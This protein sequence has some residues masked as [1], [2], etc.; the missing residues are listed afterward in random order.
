MSFIS[1]LIINVSAFRIKIGEKLITLSN[2]IGNLP[3]LNTNN[4]TNLVA[5][6]N[7]V[8]ANSIQTLSTG[9]DTQPGRVEISN[10]NAIQLRDLSTGTKMDGNSRLLTSAFKP[11]VTNAGMTN[12]PSTTVGAG[13]RIERL[14]TSIAQSGFDI[15]KVANQDYLWYKTFDGLDTE[16]NWKILA[17]RD[18]IT[19]QLG[20]FLPLTGGLMNLDASIGLRNTGQIDKHIPSTTGGWARN[21]IRLVNTSG[22]NVLDVGMGYYG[23]GETIY[24][25]YMG[26][27]AYNNGN[28]IRWTPDSKVGINMSA[29][30]VPSANLDVNG[31][32]RFRNLQNGLLRT[33]GSGNISID[34]NSYALLSQVYT[35]AQA[36]GLFVG[37]NGVETINDTKTFSSSPVVPNGTLLGHTVNLGQ[38]NS[39]IE[40]IELTPGPAGTNGTNGKTWYSSTA[41]PANTLGVVGDF[42]L[43]TTTWDV[44]EKT[45]TSVWTLRGNIK[46]ETGAQG[47]AGTNGANGTSATI[48]SAS[49]TVNANVGTPAVSVTLG[50]T[51]SARTFAFAFS[52]LK[53]ATGNTGA[54]G[55]TGS[56][57]TNGIDG[58]T[59]LSGTTNPA[60]SLGTIGDWYLNRTTWIMFEKTANTV[61]TN[62]GTIKGDTGAEGPQGPPGSGALN[63][64]YLNVRIN[65]LTPDNVNGL[66]EKS[67]ENNF[68]STLKDSGQGFQ[69]SV[70]SSNGYWVDVRDYPNDFFNTWGVGRFGDP[71]FVTEGTISIGEN[72]YYANLIAEEETYLVCYLDAVNNDFFF[73]FMTHQQVVYYK[74][75][76]TQKGNFV[77]LGNLI[78]KDDKIYLRVDPKFF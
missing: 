39:A 31:T 71:E 38:L 29:S 6:I 12:Y 64:K 17:D 47:I 40:A 43:N 42:H 26:G 36:L 73:E 37:K 23:S 2:R 41:V 13:L 75:E 15:Y 10:G 53:G 1:D 8:N 14:S 21:I 52:N 32:I 59:I 25:S 66:I 63:D 50:G 68:F 55:A 65:N 54:T 48:T 74:R 22:D 78:N 58:K 72:S 11:Y 35:Q 16:R 18:W 61:W 19:I 4:K 77:V 20:N 30:W 69:A 33:D 57:G 5:A 49:A 45:A 44:R 76:A 46:G 67:D 62:R 9:S 7:E 27:L 24:Y 56:N 28:A 70:L 51:A 60:T 34:N 3:S